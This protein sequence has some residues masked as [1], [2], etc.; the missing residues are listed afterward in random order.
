MAPRPFPNLNTL[1]QRHNGLTRAV[2]LNFAEAA[3]VRLSRHHQSPCEIVVTVTGQ[4]PRTFELTWKK[5]GDREQRAWANIIDAVEAGACA[6]AIAAV[7]VTHELF[8]VARAE[9]LTGADYYVGP[10]GA[11]LE[12]AYRLEVSGTDAGSEGHLRSRLTQKIKQTKAG[13][14]T[15]PAVACVVGFKI[16]SILVSD[17]Q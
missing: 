2:C 10:A 4:E 13:T 9:T 15:S 6:M 11:D 7:E 14:G 12:T 8:A 1:H 17:L 3:R 5:V 16:G